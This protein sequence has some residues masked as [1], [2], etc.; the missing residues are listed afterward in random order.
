MISPKK[1]VWNGMSSIS[2]PF[3]ITTEFSF[4]GDD[5]ESEA[6]LSREAVASESHNGS[7][8]R[9][10]GYKWSESMSPTIT[11]IKENFEDF[12]ID[13][14]RK[15]LKWLTSR[16]TAGFLDIYDDKNSNAILYSILGN[17]TGVKQYKAGNGR[18]IGI[19][20]TFESLAPYA[21]SGLQ[22]IKQIYDEET[23]AFDNVLKITINTDDQA[24]PVMPKITI[25]FKDS[26]EEKLDVKI[27]N[28]WTD[29]DQ[30]SHVETMKITNNNPMETIVVDGANKVISSSLTYRQFGDDFEHWKWFPLYDGKNTITI[31]GNCEVAFEYREIRKIGEI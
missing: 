13:E 15:I 2:I 5:G 18:V 21:F 17:F 27:Q 10:S 25:K 31:T 19:T 24:T 1:I 8:K 29:M 4:D 7:L 14:S 28:V 30:I 22:T 3:N 16:K 11:I 20:A 9:A 12:T 6:Y 26:S 23:G